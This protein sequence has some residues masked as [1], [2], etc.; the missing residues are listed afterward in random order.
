MNLLAGL[1]KFGLSGG[2]ELDITK[3]ESKNQKKNVKTASSTE[4]P[5]EEKDFLLDKIIEC[6]V[7]DSKFHTLVVKTGKAK[8]L[9]PDNDLRPN[10]KGIDT[11][12]YDVSTCPYCGYAALNKNF[13]HIS[14]TQIKWIKEA[15][16]D[17]KPVKDF[18]AE[19]Y[20]YDRAVDRY[21]LALV[22]AMA[23]RGKMSEKAYICLKIAWL[24]RSEYKE[25]KADTDELKQ[26]KAMILEEYNGF[27]K[28]AYEGF[29]KAISTETAPYEG[30]DD[31]T[32]QFMLANMALYFKDY[33]AASKMVANLLTAPAT[34]PRVKDKCVDL[35]ETILAEI[36][37]NKSGE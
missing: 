27:Y 21:K 37:K 35:K 30:M 20:S 29:Q 6:P 1:E 14:M 10:F 28:Q 3:E 4:K 9:E 12:K 18:A 23:K 5:A 8:R 2:D 31:S 24:R 16:K 15:M 33:S 13:V 36:K 11:V 25:I 19:T 22:N 32:I 34:P 7:C 26:K 17:F